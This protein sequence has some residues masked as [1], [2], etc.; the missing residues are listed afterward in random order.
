LRGRGALAALAEGA[1]KPAWET[2]DPSA[3]ARAMSE[4][5]ERY[6][7]DLLEHANVPRANV[8]STAHG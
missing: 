6:Q 3:V 4:F 5:R 2:G 7:A 8:A 1:L